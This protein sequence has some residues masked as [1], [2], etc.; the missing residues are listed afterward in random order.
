MSE[1][2]DLLNNLKIDRSKNPIEDE[3][4]SRKLIILGLAVFIVGVFSWIFLSED[5]LKEVTTF[6]VK[7]LQMSDSSATS[8]L[9]ASGYVVAR[10]RATVSS[11]M[12]G[13][14]MKVCFLH[15]SI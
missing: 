3:S 10:R 15:K 13:K 12:T 2:E 7:S 11:K 5:E 8:I 14:V 1:R 6:T 9:D 4:S